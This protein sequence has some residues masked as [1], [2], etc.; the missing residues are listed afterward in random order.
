MVERPGNKAM[1]VLADFVHTHT[2]IKI[3]ETV[4]NDVGMA[5]QKVCKQGRHDIN[6]KVN[7]QAQSLHLFHT[8]VQL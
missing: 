1:T 2:L 8:R 3:I 6:V 4:E 7:I 5:C